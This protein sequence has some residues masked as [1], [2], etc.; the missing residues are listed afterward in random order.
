M[1]YKYKQ[2]KQLVATFPFSKGREGNGIPI[3]SKHKGM[4]KYRQRKTN[5][6]KYH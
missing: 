6:L 1:C 5:F 3:R 4:V 2:P